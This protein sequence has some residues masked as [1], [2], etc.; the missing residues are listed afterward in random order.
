MR[1]ILRTWRLGAERRPEAEQIG[2]RIAA[3]EVRGDPAWSC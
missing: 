1:S 3:R 2:V